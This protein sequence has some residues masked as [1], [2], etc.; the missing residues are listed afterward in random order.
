LSDNQVQDIHI[1]DRGIIWLATWK[2]GLNR[3]DPKAKQFTHYLPDPDNPA[4]L[5]ALQSIAQDASGHIWIG[6]FGGGVSHFDPGTEQFTHY[7]HDPDDP[8]SLGNWL[9]KSLYVDRSNVLWIGTSGGLNSFDAETGRFNRHTDEMF[10]GNLVN[11][12]Y[13]R[14]ARIFWIGADNGLHKFHPEDGTL[15]TYTIKH[16]LPSGYIVGILED[17]PG[18]LWISTAKGLSLFN[19][20]TE[21][22]KNF[23]RESGLQEKGFVYKSAYETRDG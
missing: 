15:A 11:T 19:P 12:I 3:F 13:E 1:D 7:R 17:T 2:G 23:D 22:F 14:E 20:D 6:A 16:G 4:P 21:T 10:A 18:N 8:Y 5:S 9:V